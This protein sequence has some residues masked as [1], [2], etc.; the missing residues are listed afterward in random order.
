MIALPTDTL[1]GLGC[2]FGRPRAIE[3]VARL[4]GIDRARR[5]LTFLLPDLGVVARYA[6]VT[7]AGH[8]ILSRILPGPY[9]VELEATAAVPDAFVVGN[10][11]TIGV[12]VP[13]RPFCE[14]LLWS[15]ALPVLTATAKARDGRALTTAAEIAEE[16]GADLDLVVDGGVAD[17]PPST[18]VSL[19]DDWVTV[20]RQG[21]GDPSL[22][23]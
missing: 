2:A 7:E 14:R 11:R 4:R 1:Y 8:R 12:R 17:G 5:P 20:L 9:C 3:R 18:V 10:R 16:L 21:R 6:Q 13:D 19:V 23:L 22:L 15:L